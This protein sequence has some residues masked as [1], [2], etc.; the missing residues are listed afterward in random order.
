V[1]PLELFS[2]SPL[3]NYCASAASMLFE[4]AAD[5]FLSFPSAFY[6]RV[7]PTWDQRSPLVASSRS[8]HLFYY[9]GL[10]AASSSSSSTGTLSNI[11]HRMFER[12][13]LLSGLF[14]FLKYCKPAPSAPAKRLTLSP[15]PRALFSP[16]RATRAL[17]T[18][19]VSAPPRC[20]KQPPYTPPARS[21]RMLFLANCRLL[22]SCHLL[23]LIDICAYSTS[24]KLIPL[25]LS[26]S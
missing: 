14:L 12:E 9:G 4:P 3:E 25:A 5:F 8:S 1:A 24:G 6:S 15:R 26:R 13:S 18:L 10:A 16:H 23:L 11:S 20:L 2:S 22:L 19:A 7:F 21:C 17:A